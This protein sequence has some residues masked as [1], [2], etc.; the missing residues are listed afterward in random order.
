MDITQV[1]WN[2]RYLQN[3][4]PW[5]TNAPSSELVRV[6]EE[7]RIGPCRA[8]DV[9][10]GTGTNAVYLASRGFDVTAV[11]LAPLAIEAAR[12]RAQ[13]AGV[14]C[15]FIEADT[16]NLPGLGPTFDFI[17]DCGCFHIMRHINERAMIRVYERQLAPQG[18]L[19]VLAGNANEENPPEGG[20]PRVSEAE[21]RQAFDGFDI[22]H[23]RPFRFDSVVGR[24]FHPLAWSLLVRRN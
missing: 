12:R 13:A 18:W 3:D 22:V 11:D 7:C 21:L 14:A 20:P 4:A 8:L 19:L 2:Q 15:R 6:L 24:D 9:G 16:L 1:D 23:L 17:L 10:C 5:D